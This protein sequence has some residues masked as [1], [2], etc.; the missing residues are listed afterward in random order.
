MVWSPTGWG[1][2][3]IDGDDGTSLILP[4]EQWGP[5]GEALVV[6]REQARLVPATRLP[7]FR[8]LVRLR[9]V[10][11]VVPAAPGWTIDAHMLGSQLP[12]TTPIAAWV[13]DGEGHFSAVAGVADSV[14]R[15]GENPDP[16]GEYV[17]RQA[18][19]SRYRIV[20]PPS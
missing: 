11:A 13:M 12:F 14:S 18:M 17:L 4:V 1:V 6:D 16:E 20:P 5:K 8:E 7:N 2:R 10:V 9:R 19:S 15:M 3:V